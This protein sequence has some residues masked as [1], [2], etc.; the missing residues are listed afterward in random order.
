MNPDDPR[1]GG[2]RRAPEL[3]TLERKLGMTERA[4]KWLKWIAV[5]VALATTA[6]V[7]LGARVSSLEKDLALIVATAKSKE[8]A[9]A[10]QNLVITKLEEMEKR[11]VIRLDSIDK[12]LDKREAR[13]GRP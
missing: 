6:W 8:S 3:S 4:A 1:S 12:R 5:T 7:T 10:D 13:N 11:M 9:A 2:D